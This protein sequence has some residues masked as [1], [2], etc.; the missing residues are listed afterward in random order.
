[1]AIVLD[2]NIEKSVRSIGEY[3]IMIYFYFLQESHWTLTSLKYL[4]TSNNNCDDIE[5]F[6]ED[7]EQA[8]VLCRQQDPLIIMGDFNVKIGERREEKRVG[9]HRLDIRNMP[10]EKL[11]K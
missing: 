3:Q 5:K 10:G 1:M 4:Q 9:P 6:Y 8:K 11:I 2:T 7:L